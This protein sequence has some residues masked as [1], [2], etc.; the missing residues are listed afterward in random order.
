MIP[1]GFYDERQRAGHFLSFVNLVA[2]QKNDVID[3]ALEKE[4]ED[5]E[6]VD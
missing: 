1:L 4:L 5:L 3:K 2:N 6:L